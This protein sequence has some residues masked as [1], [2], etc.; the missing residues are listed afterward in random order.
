MRKQDPKAGISGNHINRNYR[1]IM[2]KH[3][4]YTFLF[5]FILT[6]FITLLG[7]INVVEIKEKYLN[8]LFGTLILELI[9]SVIALFKAADFFN[10]TQSQPKD[11]N[12]SETK[13]IKT[14][15]SEIDNIVKQ[16]D[17]SKNIDIT[18]LSPDK[19]ASDYFTKLNVLE[20]RFHEREEFVNNLDG[21]KV[22]WS[23]YVDSVSGGKANDDKITVSIRTKED[24]L[25]QSFQASFPYEF[26]TKLFSLNKNDVICVKGTIRTDIRRMPDV[27][28]ES[29]ELINP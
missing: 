10:E 23:G 6:A 12:E 11:K 20:H 18:K 22:S 26:K 4:F 14:I 25:Y 24:V 1:E 29:I 7:V 9:A 28:A 16:K 3:L 17:T 13:A 21:S 15:K 27:N 5:I 19:S 8:I 2:K